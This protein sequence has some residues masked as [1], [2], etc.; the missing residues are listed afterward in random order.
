M[1]TKMGKHDCHKKNCKCK[2]CVVKYRKVKCVYQK[3]KKCKY[4]INIS[5]DKNRNICDA[6]TGLWNATLI[7]PAGSAVVNSPCNLGRYN[8]VNGTVHAVAA[9]ALD[10]SGRM[11]KTD[12]A[13]A[14]LTLPVPAANNSNFKG[15]IV[16]VVAVGE[17]H[18]N[19]IAVGRFEYQ[20]A[21][22]ARIK[23]DSVVI[24]TNEDIAPTVRPC[25]QVWIKMTYDCTS[26]C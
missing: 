1:N 13:R 6:D 8:V 21:T 19:S 4:D 20:E 2:K 23:S 3:D 7:H 16:Y 10:L 12:F 24:A 26:C 25:A 9:F 22:V 5:C 17:N 15:V 11:V 18:K 14:I